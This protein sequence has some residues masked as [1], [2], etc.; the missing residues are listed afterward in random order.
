MTFTNA[1]CQQA[2]CAPSRASLLTGLLPDTTGVITLKTYFRDTAPQAITLPQIFRENGWTS[3]GI[4]KTFHVKEKEENGKSW[5]EPWTHGNRSALYV[6]PD[7]VRVIEDMVAKSG[8]KTPSERREA[9]AKYSRYG[10]SSEWPDLPDSAFPDGQCADNLVA[11]LKKFAETKEPFFLG[12][13]FIKPHL[14]FSAPKKYWDLYKR[15]DIRLPEWLKA[16]DGSPSFVVHNSP[17]LREYLDIG[18]GKISDEKAKE[19]IH[20]YYANVSFVDAQVGKLLDALEEFGLAK[21]TVIVLWGDH[22]F[23]LGDHGLWTKMTNFEQSMRVPLIIHVPGMKNKGEVCSAPTEFVDIYPTVCELAG[24]PAPEFLEGVSLLRLLENPKA[25]WK[26]AAFS[27]F[28]R[29]NEE[30]T[31]V[32]PAGMMGYSMR[33]DR[34]RYTEWVTNDGWNLRDKERPQ[35]KHPAEGNRV[36]AAEFYDYQNDPM[37]TRNLVDAP[38]Y[39]E[40][41]EKHR[42]LMEGG[43]RGVRDA[44]LGLESVR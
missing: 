8:A 40:E 5:S 11:R 23:H 9:M 17:E 31:Q 16:P 41:V 39:K 18:R 4:G 42:K 36:V 38:E 6:D 15:E 43:W 19:L 1:H 20:G 44:L 12:V 3:V 10:P 14:P 22:G 34:Y 35:W 27:Q 13:G 28:Q 24:I 37:E 2:L 30:A 29:D 32:A 33:T 25:K 7:N 26:E 21:N